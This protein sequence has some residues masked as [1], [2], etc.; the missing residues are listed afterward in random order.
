MNGKFFLDTN[1]I[2]Q[3]AIVLASAKLNNCQLITADKDLL[4]LKE[5]TNIIDS[6]E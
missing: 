4:K 3:H 6:N 5:Y 1:A 2:I